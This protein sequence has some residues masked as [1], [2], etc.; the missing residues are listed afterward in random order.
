MM[1]GN[2]NVKK[3]NEFGLLPQQKIVNWKTCICVVQDGAFSVTFGSYLLILLQ[4][5]PFLHYH[6]NSQE[7]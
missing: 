5:N 1:H 4:K 7:E 3:D 2:V 6:I